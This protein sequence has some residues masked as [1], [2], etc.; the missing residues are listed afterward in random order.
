MG[1]SRLEDIVAHQFAEEFKLEVY[2]LINASP[3]AR[4][5]FKFNDQLRRAASGIGPAIAEGFGHGTTLSA[6]APQ[7]ARQPA[8]TRRRRQADKSRRR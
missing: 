3:G 4:R 6:R 8:K 5:D 1:F 2:T 7:P